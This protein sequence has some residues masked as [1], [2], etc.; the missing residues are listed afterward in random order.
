[1]SSNGLEHQIK[2]LST[3]DAS[4]DYIKIWRK[5]NVIGSLFTWKWERNNNNTHF[6]D[7]SNAVAH[8]HIVLMAV[9]PLHPSAALSNPSFYS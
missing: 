7:L 5:Y 9:M 2:T 8:S 6:I 4:I 1:M 3:N